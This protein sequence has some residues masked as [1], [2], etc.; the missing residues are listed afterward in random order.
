MDSKQLRKLLADRMGRSLADIDA[1]T[2]GLSVVIRQNCSNL[3]T[4]AVPTFGSFVPVKHNEEV[5]RDLS[6]GKSM[7]MPPE[8]VLE[9]EPAAN[10]VNRLQPT[11]RVL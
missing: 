10:L 3:D 4:V 9:F 8:I 6:T 7:L 5:T 11:E 2:E 1:L